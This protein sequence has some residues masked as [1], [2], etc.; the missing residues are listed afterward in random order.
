M[1]QIMEKQ[2][3]SA[4]QQLGRDL[5]LFQRVEDGVADYGW[6][7]WEADTAAVV[8]GRFGNA[9][10]EVFERQCQQDGVPVVRRCS[11]GGAVVVGRGC[12]NFA[13]VFAL[14]AHQELVDVAR[15][16]TIV[17]H[18]IAGMLAI[19]GLS[20]AGGTDLVVDGRKVSGSAQRRGRRTLLHHGT[21]LYDFDPML[22]ARYL[23]EPPRQPEYRERRPH[24]DFM[25]CLDVPR[26]VL[27]ARLS[28]GLASLA[29]MT[30]AC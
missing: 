28:E 30:E 3:G 23:R 6:R 13:L 22:A 1:P 14:P 17:L 2:D 8:L 10:N 5:Q 18:R 24:A 21:L 7:L 12:L 27:M 15:S 4:E 9:A 29:P 11:G 25:G 19:E 16:F 26:E 20:I